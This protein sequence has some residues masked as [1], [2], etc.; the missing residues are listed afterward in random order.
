[1]V[2]NAGSR[3]RDV[4]AAVR[5]AWLETYY[6]HQAAA[7]LGEVRPLFVDLASISQSLFSVGRARQPAVLQAALELSRLDDRLLQ[8]DTQAL[9]ARAALQQWVGEHASRP[10]PSRMPSWPELPDPGTLREGLAQHP[11]MQ[12]AEARTLAQSHAVELA[13]EQFKPG[14]MIDLGYGYRDGSLP[15]GEPRS[16]FV[17]LMVSVDLPLRRR[18]RQSQD[19]KA[20]LQ[21]RRA[22]EQSRAELLRRLS[23]ELQREYDR[24]QLLAQ[25]IAG[26]EQR[27]LVQADERAQASLAAYQSDDGQLDEV[28]RGYIDQLE[29]R[30]AHLRLQVERAQ[31][32]AVLANLGGLSL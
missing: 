20:A 12:A 14:W 30:L 25:R 17:S 7:I 28:L 6:W 15:S 16:D 13:R 26:Y 2:A 10:L 4:R 27:I 9:A 22:A 8:V 29:T 3:G 5:Q 11:A 24:S 19:L 23:S 32:F 18:H 21:E 31:S 1:M